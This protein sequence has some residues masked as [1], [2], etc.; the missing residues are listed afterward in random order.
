[1]IIEQ[2]DKPLPGSL[3]PTLAGGYYTDPNVFAAEQER[4]FEESWFCVLHGSDIEKPGDCT[5]TFPDVDQQVPEGDKPA[6]AGDQ[7]PASTSAA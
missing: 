1:M 2:L 5:L 3:M 4:I 7:P 6:P